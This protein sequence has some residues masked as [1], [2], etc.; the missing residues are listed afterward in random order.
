MA[1]TI[2]WQAVKALAD[3]MSPLF[4]QSNIH[5]LSAVHRRA[6]ETDWALFYGYSDKQDGPSQ[7]PFHEETVTAVFQVVRFGDDENAL[8]E[9]DERVG[10]MERLAAQDGSLG[11]LAMWTKPRAS[12][13]GVLTKDSSADA[14]YW[15]RVTFEIRVRRVYGDPFTS[16]S[17]P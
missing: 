9:L 3:R 16:E 15:Q 1:H 13:P 2:R 10:E 5:E 11:G 17:A 14:K 8:S 4:G 7:T 6:G 12:E